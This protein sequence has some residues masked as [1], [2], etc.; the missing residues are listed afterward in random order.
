MIP[1][2]QQNSWLVQGHVLHIPMLLPFVSH[3]FKLIVMDLIA[4]HDE[5]MC[6]EEEEGDI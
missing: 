3:P 6:M 5:K 2:Q 1:I 4:N